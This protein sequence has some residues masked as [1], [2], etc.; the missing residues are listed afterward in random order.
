M[1]QSFSQL[2]DNV[3]NEIEILNRENEM[4]KAEA[5]AV[6]DPKKSLSALAEIEGRTK[7]YTQDIDET[8]ALESLLNGELKGV[9][10]FAETSKEA[11]F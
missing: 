7:K 1:R 8:F 4:D 2:A 6:V 11:P 3:K 10:T 5:K 9:D